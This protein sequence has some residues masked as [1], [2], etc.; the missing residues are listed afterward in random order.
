MPVLCEEVSSICGRGAILLRCQVADG[1]WKGE[2]RT[3][4][5]PFGQACA[6]AM[7]SGYRTPL[8]VV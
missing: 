1:V 2:V 3:V 8:K 7:E 6:P 5:T 4:P